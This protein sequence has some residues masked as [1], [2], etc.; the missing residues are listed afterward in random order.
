MGLAMSIRSQPVFLQAGRLIAALRSVRPLRALSGRLFPHNVVV[1]RSDGSLDHYWLRMRWTGAYELLRRSEKQAGPAILVVGDGLPYRRRLETLPLS[2][3]AR[4]TLLAAA[5]NEFPFADGTVG[6]ALG[7]RDHGGYLYALENTH[8][9]AIRQA[10][11]DPVAVLVA[12]DPD[13]P[14]AVRVAIDVFE[15]AGYLVSCGGSP[16]LISRRH[17]LNTF[18]VLTAITLCVLALWLITFSGKVV[19]NYLQHELADARKRYGDLPAIYQATRQ[20]ENILG[21]VAEYRNSGGGRTQQL[22]AT[23]FASLP[24]GHSIARIELK[25]GVLTVSGIGDK[26]EDWLGP[27][28]FHPA[29]IVVE[30]IGNRSRYRAQVNISQVV[31]QKENDAR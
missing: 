9:D 30:T 15:R 5:P 27:I 17:A 3:K 16:H 21:E 18:L 25:E 4:A 11:V 31:L 22:L 19:G 24:P 29:D 14:I 1:R 8:I 2:K 12:D 26:A 6:Y 7:F 28:G 10:G 20:M 23:L 13:S